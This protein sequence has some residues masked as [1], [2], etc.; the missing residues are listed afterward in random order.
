MAMVKVITRFVSGYCLHLVG[1]FAEMYSCIF[2]LRAHLVVAGV[3]VGLVSFQFSCL[4][5]VMILCTASSGGSVV[6]KQRVMDGGGG[7]HPP[8]VDSSV[9]KDSMPSQVAV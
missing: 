5:V 2:S 9:P 1:V 3:G 8:S 6:F 4:A 7:F